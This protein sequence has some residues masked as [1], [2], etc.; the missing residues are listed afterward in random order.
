MTKPF[1]PS[2]NEEII[3]GLFRAIELTEHATKC[4]LNVRTA[5]VRCDDPLLAYYAKDEQPDPRYSRRR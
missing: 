4:E 5:T 2:H 3:K 1:D